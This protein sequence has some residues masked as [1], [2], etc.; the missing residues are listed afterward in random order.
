[1]DLSDL[2]PYCT[3]DYLIVNYIQRPDKN[4]V[5]NLVVLSVLKILLVLQ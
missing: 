5:N 4:K 2:F 3:E 1:M